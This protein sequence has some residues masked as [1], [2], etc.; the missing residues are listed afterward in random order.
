MRRV[1]GGLIDAVRFQMLQLLFVFA[2]EEE[3]LRDEFALAKGERI[4]YQETMMILY[5]LC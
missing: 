3:P 5:L 2:R 4:T 1:Q